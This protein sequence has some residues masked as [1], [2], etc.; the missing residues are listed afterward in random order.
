MH[1]SG[2]FTTGSATANGSGTAT[3]SRSPGHRSEPYMTTSG[4]AA[5]KSCFQTMRRPASRAA[6]FRITASGGRALGKSTS[7]PKARRPCFGC[8]PGCR[9]SARHAP[10]NFAWLPTRRKFPSHTGS[11]AWK[12]GRFISCSSSIFQS[13]SRPAAA[14]RCRAAGSA[15]SIHPSALARPAAANSPGRTPKVSGGEAD[16][17]HIPPRES[18]RARVSL[19]KG[20]AGALVRRR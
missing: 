16:L 13:G 12:R 18:R 2:T 14:S 10:R 5:G 20:P 3:T 17:R 15:A 9:S 11:G 6:H 4:R 19:R 1:G 8:R 7:A